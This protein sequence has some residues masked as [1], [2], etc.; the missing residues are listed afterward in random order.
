MSEEKPRD[1]RFTEEM[2]LEFDDEDNSEE[3]EVAKVKKDIS[4]Q[5]V[6]PDA[7]ELRKHL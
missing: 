4:D 5:L 2:Q 3:G 1:D 7:E 6:G